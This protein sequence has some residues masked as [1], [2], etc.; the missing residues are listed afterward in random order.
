VGYQHA[1]A[2][3]VLQAHYR[4]PLDFTL[5]R[6]PPRRRWQGLNQLWLGLKPALQALLALGW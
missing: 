6:S 2:F 5:K 1:L 3:F 4:K